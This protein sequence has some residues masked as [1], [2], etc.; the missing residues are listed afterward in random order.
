MTV[1]NSWKSIWDKKG[2]QIHSIDDLT[3]SD[4]IREDGF[5]SGAGDHTQESWLELSEMVYRTLAVSPDSK[6]LEVGCGCGA[7]VFPAY[8]LGAR[9]TGIDYSRQLVAGAKMVMPEG[10]FLQAE[11]A[12]LPITSEQ[13]NVVLCHSVFQYFSSEQYAEN[14][15]Y[16]MVRVLAKGEASIGILDVND[17]DKQDAFYRVRGES[18]GK[19]TYREKYQDRPHRFYHKEWFSDLL[20]QAGFVVEIADQDIDG[21]GNSAFRYNVFAHRF[22]N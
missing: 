10:V 3:L 13:F 22:I 1:R 15:V 5:D 7:F 4:M 16:E 18:I 19:E 9:I 8:R 17:A 12:R 11:A 2:S 6:V 21:Y 20:Q 14:T